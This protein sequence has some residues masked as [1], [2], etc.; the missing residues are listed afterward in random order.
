MII[1]IVVIQL[2]DKTAELESRR[3]ATFTI[4]GNVDRNC[5]GVTFCLPW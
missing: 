3:E 4:T 1:F 5:P 2:E